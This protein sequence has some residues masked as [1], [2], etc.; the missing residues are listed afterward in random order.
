MDNMLTKKQCEELI[1]AN[2]NL[3][4][5]DL[6]SHV[7]YEYCDIFNWRNHEILAPLTFKAIE[8]YKVRFPEIELTPNCWRL[9]VWRFKH[10]PPGYHFKEWHSEQ[11]HEYPHR[12]ASM[13]IY[14]SDH[15]CGT[16]FIATGEVIKSKA[17]RV[18][19]FPSSWTHTHRG[20][21][22]PENKSRYIMSIY[23]ELMN[24]RSRV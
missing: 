19:M 2:T 9:E 24:Q 13:M 10:F 14:L 23:A 8:E 17:G 4:N 16:E 22:C 11:S 21:L 5:S 18:V 12:I 6:E 7:G 15:D 3:D 20:Q 1:E